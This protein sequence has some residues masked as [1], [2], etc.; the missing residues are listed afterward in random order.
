MRLRLRIAIALAVSFVVAGAIVLA[1]SSFTYQQ[2]VTGTPREQM[3]Q[4]LKLQGVSRAQAEAY[5]RAHPDSV[6]N[7]P[8]SAPLPN[9]RPSV[10]QAFQEVQR[11]AQRDAVHR[12]RVWTAVALGL[13]GLA[14]AVV[15]WM[16]AGR[17]LKA[18]RRITARAREASATRLWSRVALDGPDDEIK[19]LGDTFDDMLDRLERAFAAQRRF[20]GQVSHEIRTPLA[21]ISSETD[22]LL[23]DAEPHQRESL[24]QVQAAT[25]R[26]DRIIS[27]LLALSRSGSGDIDPRE[28]DLDA[29]A[30]DVLGELVND[31]SWRDVRVDLDLDAAPVLA[32]R[33]L[34]ERAIS[35]LLTNAVRHNRPEGWV[36][37]RTWARGSWSVLEV[38]NSTGIAD[39]DG[40]RGSG[41]GL[42]V[43]DSVVT[44][45]GGEVV[46]NDDVPGVVSVEVRLPESASP[47]NAAEPARPAAGIRA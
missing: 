3:D 29:V 11:A 44:A 19:E 41:I 5:V 23:Q 46:W 31:P 18:I 34:L 13:M 37:V 32:D 27:A 40:D 6:F 16:I 30:G 33:A 20:S 8:G 26:A 25:Q 15:G 45:H 22:L 12:A 47:G 38:A 43:V 35:N 10:N 21:I 17:T 14:A 9:G 28:V 7:W 42:T 1:I 39:R 2:A 4:M 36:S 24:H